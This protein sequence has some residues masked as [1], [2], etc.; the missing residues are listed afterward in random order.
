MP[1]GEALPAFTKD[2]LAKAHRL[3]AAKVAYMMGRKFEEGDWTQIYCRS[4][5]YGIPDWSNLN[6]DVELPG[7]AIEQKMLKRV[8]SQP[9]SQ[10]C[11]TWLMHPSLTRQISLPVGNDPNDAMRKVIGDYE[12]VLHSR[13]E[14]N[15]R[16]YGG[17]S[18]E[19]R[20]GWL[21]Y[22]SSLRE[23]MYFEE[24]TVNLDPATHTRSGRRDQPADH[25]AVAETSGS[26]KPGQGR[27]SGRLPVP[28]LEQRFNLTSGFP[29]RQIP[30]S[31]YLQLRGF[32][33]MG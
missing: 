30:I 29:L 9:I 22:Q 6:V 14:R 15:M 21:I 26:I 2:E 13:R 25:A 19:M 16:R 31:I 20:S 7:L 4:K 8:D 1:P 12:H 27:R 28:A 3:L 24:E 17:T 11:G 18:V 10:W 5:G 33:R 32:G 23:F